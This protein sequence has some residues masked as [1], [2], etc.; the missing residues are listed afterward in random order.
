MVKTKYFLKIGWIVHLILPSCDISKAPGA[1][2]LL[3]LPGSTA[4]LLLQRDSIHGLL[5]CS[6][7]QYNK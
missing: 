4:L 6:C 3:Q 1:Q 7:T 2:S 5:S